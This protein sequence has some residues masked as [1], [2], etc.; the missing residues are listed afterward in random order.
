VEWLNV[1]ALGDFLRRHRERLGL[2]QEELAERVASGVA[3]E[4]ISNVERGRVRPRRHTLHAL[5]AALDLGE[6]ERRALLATWQHPTARPSPAPSDGPAATRSLPPW[7]ATPL[8]RREREVASVA[9][10]LRRPEVRL[11]TLTGVGGV[12]KTRLALEVADQLRETFPDGVIWV[13]LAP[14]AEGALVAAAVA[15]AA[16]VAEARGRSPG[17]WPCMV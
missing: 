11:L 9:G 2:T 15:A 16:G 1:L 14:L 8:I 3:V 17:E 13:E 7:P 4:T 12:G 6:A 5:N 10:L